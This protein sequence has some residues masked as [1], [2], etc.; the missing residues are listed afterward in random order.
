MMKSIPIKVFVL[1]EEEYIEISY[2]ELQR[3]K[4]TDSD[5][6]N[7]RFLLLQGMLM[8]VSEE[9]YLTFNRIESRKNYLKKLSMKNGE[10]FYE[11]LTTDEFRGEDILVDTKEDVYEVVEQKIVLDKLHAAL[12]LLTKEERKLIHLLFYEGKTERTIAK[13]QNVSQVTIHK[14]K[15]KIMTKLRNW[16]EK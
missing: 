6:N 12:E 11:E 13:Q 10:F 16:L 15:Q 5:Y 8:E 4:S 14:R 2:E 7:K 1:N 9:E 3:R